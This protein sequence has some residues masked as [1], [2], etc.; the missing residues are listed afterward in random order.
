M[1]SIPAGI[2]NKYKNAVDELITNTNTGDRCEVIY[3]PKKVPCDCVGLAGN[4]GSSLPDGSPNIFGNDCPICGGTNFKYEPSTE[5]IMVNVYPDKG[6]WSKLTNIQVP[7]SEIMIRGFISDL[8]KIQKM[9][10]MKVFVK[11][12]QYGNWNYKLS[13]EPLPHG[14][15]QFY[16]LA[17]LKR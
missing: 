10:S 12:E 16:F 15:G 9:V 5:Y 3:P 4:I 8:D 1:I 6:S 17:F 13:G 2:F 11:N 7:D 14:F